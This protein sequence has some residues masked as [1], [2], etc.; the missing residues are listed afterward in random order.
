[1]ALPPHLDTLLLAL[2]VSWIGT[3]KQYAGRLHREHVDK[4]DVRIV[5]FIDADH[6]VLMRMWEKHQRRYQ[7]MGYQILNG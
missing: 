3:L 1:M 7:A 4:S 6:P 2:P 5:D